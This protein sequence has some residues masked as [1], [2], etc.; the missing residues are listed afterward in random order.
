VVADE[1]HLAPVLEAL[2]IVKADAP[3]TSRF[4]T[5][6]TPPATANAH[7][8]QPKL[9]LRHHP[10]P[11]SAPTPP[12][13]RSVHESAHHAQA[14]CHCTLQAARLPQAPRKLN[15]NSRPQRLARCLRSETPMNQN[16]FY[17]IGVVVVVGVVLRFVL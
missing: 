15:C 3:T 12:P 9:V 17:I 13:Q 1:G 16:I 2:T 4:P 7:E 14:V 10:R 11:F 8:N 5:A 6:S